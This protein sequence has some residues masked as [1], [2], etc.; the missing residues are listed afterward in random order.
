MLLKK[1]NNLNVFIK[2]VEIRCG[3]VKKPCALQ[4]GKNIQENKRLNPKYLINV[5]KPQLT[6]ISAP[7]GVS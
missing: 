2:T 5:R 7:G 1:I 4:I 3:M 6:S